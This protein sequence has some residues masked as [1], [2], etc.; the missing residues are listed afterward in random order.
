MQKRHKGGPR[1][2]GRKNRITVKTENLTCLPTSERHPGKY[3]YRRGRAVF[4]CTLKHG[5]TT[6][7]NL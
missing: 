4:Q 1:E 7:I 6:T 5:Q 2:Y 3:V